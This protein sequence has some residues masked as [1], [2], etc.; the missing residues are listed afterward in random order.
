MLKSLKRDVRWAV[1]VGS[2]FPK[3]DLICISQLGVMREK[4]LREV[5]IDN[6]G[7][8]MCR[9]STGRYQR[10]SSIIVFCNLDK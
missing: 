10:L 8:I 4:F 3:E 6:L 5:Q 2:K 7:F 1:A 9:Y